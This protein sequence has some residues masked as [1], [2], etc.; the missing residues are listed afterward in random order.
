MKNSMLDYCKLILEKVRF[1]KKLFWKE[2]KK[3][4]HN[5]ADNEV[6]EL[7]EWLNSRYGPFNRV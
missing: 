5:L 1:N 4:C 2:Y 3:S 7:R 6:A